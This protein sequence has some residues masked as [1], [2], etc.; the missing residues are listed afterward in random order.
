MARTK[1][2]WPFVLSEIGVLAAL[3]TPLAEAKISFVRDFFI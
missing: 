2:S 1:S 3:A